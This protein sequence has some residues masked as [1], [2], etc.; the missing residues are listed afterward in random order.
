MPDTPSPRVDEILPVIEQVVADA[1][2]YLD[3][4]GDGP[5]R[6]STAAEAA[7]S[8]GGDL[9][10]HG[11]GA[12]AALRELH[13]R[14][15]DAAIG[16]AGPRFFHFVTG[17]TTPA[18]LGADWLAT[19]LDQVAYAWVS[20]PLALQLEKVSL[21]WLRDL[22]GLPGEG[23][24]VITSGATMANFTGLAAA[25]QWWGEQHGFDVSETGLTG[26]PRVPVLTSGFVHAS[27]TKA[28]GMLGIGRGALRMFSSNDVGEIDLEAMN[29]ALSEHAGAPSIVI[30]NAGEVNAGAFDPIEAVADLAERHGAWLHVDG[31]FGLFAAV[32]SRTSYL[33]EGS[34]RAQS[35]TVD[36]H[37]W[38]NVPYDCGF[39]FVDDEDLLTR[40]FRYDAPYLPDD[41]NA[42]IGGAQ[43]SSRA[44]SLAV[45]ATLRAYG[46]SGY[47][48]I[49]EASLDMAQHL[50]DRV[51]SSPQLFRLA[52]VPLNI[53]SFRF[54]PG[55]LEEDALNDLNARIGEAVLADGRVYVG[56]TR[57]GSKVAF[58][59]AFTN[60]RTTT[61][62]VDVLVEVIHEIGNR[63]AP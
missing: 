48:S 49:V 47:R 28:L 15:F 26:L 38:L 63:L 36:G 33:T 7:R 5:V 54:D 37:K 31:A 46:R 24:G 45:W 18:A 2:A 16:S 3:S 4:L 27:S 1:T 25:R 21:A 50:A 62:D 20:S 34:G 10:E 61:S 52:D 9:P 43:S 23:G 53:V 41:P 6:S 60:W 39:S 44:R 8:F 32:S 29:H 12:S 17:G 14:G 22:F 19:V 55:G 35:V 51:D 57:L 11:V 13:D 58:R 42:L 56:T 30:A 40:A 59:P